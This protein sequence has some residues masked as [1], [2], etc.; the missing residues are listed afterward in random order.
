MPIIG[1]GRV[2]THWIYVHDLVQAFI[3][4]AITPNIAGEAFL[5]AG[6]EAVTLEHT[7]KT[8]AKLAKTSVL[9]IKIPALP[10][11]ILGTIV[12]TVCKPFDIEPPLYRRRCDFFIKNRAFD[13]T[14]AHQ[15][16][17]FE[18]QLSF[19]EEAQQIYTWYKE[20]GWL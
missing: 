3:R 15:V 12:E 7:Y 5:I 9:P 6:R 18:P 8:I 17:G 19:E 11:Q 16:L 2:L 10:L 4:A 1:S 14:K 20:N 13:I